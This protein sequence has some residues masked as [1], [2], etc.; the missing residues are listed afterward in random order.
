MM[1]P[2]SFYES[3]VV[4]TFILAF[5][6]YLSGRGHGQRGRGRGQRG[7]GQRG[8]GGEEGREPARFQLR[9]PHA[10]TNIGSW[11]PRWL[12]WNIE[13][14]HLELHLLN[15]S[16]VRFENELEHGKDPQTRQFLLAEKDTLVRKRHSLIQLL[17]ALERAY[18]FASQ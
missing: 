12:R 4:I 13:N 7:R 1:L 8:R 3:I 9:M 17:Q 2:D 10:S 15:S 14:A 16:I 18:T 6:A 11:P 5:Y